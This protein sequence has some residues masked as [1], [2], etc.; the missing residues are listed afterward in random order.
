MVIGYLSLEFFFPYCRSLKDKRQIVNSFK[1]RIK[2]KY[3]VAVAELD[4]QDKWQRTHIGVVTLNSQQTIVQDWLNKI[5]AE[6]RDNVPGAEL[7][8][9]EAHFF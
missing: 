9:H 6:A 5:L 2:R 1:E 8:H 4:F 3:N 7:L